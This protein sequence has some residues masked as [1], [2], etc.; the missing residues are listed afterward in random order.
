MERCSAP[1]QDMWLSREAV[2]PATANLTVGRNISCLLY[3]SQD[4]ALVQVDPEEVEKGSVII[5]Q[6]GEKIPI[7][8]IV[9][10]G[11]S[12]LNTSALTGESPVSYTHLYC[13]LYRLWF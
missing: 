3:T 12:S 1:K 10:E 5:V 4:G 2:Q 7:D 8:G 13:D 9:L 6:P 11:F